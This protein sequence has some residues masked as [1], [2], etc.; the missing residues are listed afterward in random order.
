MRSVCNLMVFSHRG[1]SNDYRVRMYVCPVVA[2][3][4]CEACTAVPLLIV[5][6]LRSVLG[7]VAQLD[8]LDPYD[9]L[10]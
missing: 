8:I 9:G 2:K 10:Y 3:R 1:Y 6:N 4:P 7:S 5:Q